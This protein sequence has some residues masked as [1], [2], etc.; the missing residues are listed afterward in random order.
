MVNSV[1]PQFISIV[2]SG[3]G[4][5]INGFFIIIALFIMKTIS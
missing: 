4:Y 2:S 3:N 5:N 1:F